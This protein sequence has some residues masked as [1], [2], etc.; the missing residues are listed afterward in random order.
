MD[1]TVTLVLVRNACCPQDYAATW[2]KAVHY[3]KAKWDVHGYS[4]ENNTYG[5]P[6]MH[7]DAY[8]YVY[9]HKTDGS[10]AWAAG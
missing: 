7:G 1:Q 6:E 4:Y 5:A 2:L 8:S 10:G 3:S 9:N